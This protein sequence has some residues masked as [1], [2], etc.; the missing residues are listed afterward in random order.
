MAKSEVEGALHLFPPPPSPPDLHWDGRDLVITPDTAWDSGQTYIVTLQTEASDVRGNRLAGTFQTAFSTGRQI[1]SG[2][3]AGQVLQGAR[4]APGVLALC[5]A[6]ER[7]DK[8][9]EL[10]TADYVIQTD[11]AG[12]FL[13]SFLRPGDYRVFGLDDRDR[14][15]LWNIG[16]EAVAVPSLDVRVAGQPAFLPALHLARLDTV[17]PALLNCELLSESWVRLHFDGE[18]DRTVLDSVHVGLVRQADTLMPLRVLPGDSA[19]DAALVE[20]PAFEGDGRGSE[21]LLRHLYSGRPDEV[22][23]IDSVVAVQAD[24]VAVPQIWPDTSWLW[25]HPPAYVSMSFEEPLDSLVQGCFWRRPGPVLLRAEL[26]NPFEALI[27]LATDSLW[28]DSAWLVVAPGAVR[29]TRGVPWPEDTMFVALPVAP[30]D[31]S[32]RYE[33]TLEGLPVTPDQT[34]RATI[35]PTDDAILTVGIELKPGESLTGMLAEG[36]Y[37]L[38]LLSDSDG[39]GLWCSGWP[40]PFVPSERVWFPQDTVRVRAR[41]TTEFSLSLVR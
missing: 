41:F 17:K 37:L 29:S 20:L 10:D 28:S 24:F 21:I 38:S 5:Y 11:S 35:R 7:K 1:D 36:D 3:I 9:P 30:R 2:S 13:F 19:S 40:S 4:P 6:I 18:L 12:H 14:D 23:S 32:G 16:V 8:N 26:A 27:S 33:I 31:S 25:P 15:W 34:I 39:N 22:C